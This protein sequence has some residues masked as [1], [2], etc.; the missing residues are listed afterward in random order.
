MGARLQCIQSAAFFL[1]LAASLINVQPSRGGTVW[2]TWGGA[3]A[4][5]AADPVKPAGTVPADILARYQVGWEAYRRGDV[6]TALR[7]WRPLA[8]QGHA[9]SQNGLGMLY[10]IG[11]GVPQ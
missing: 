7:E 3:G 11:R 9:P 8:E 6:A 4:P 10:Q 1:S 5:K 2:D